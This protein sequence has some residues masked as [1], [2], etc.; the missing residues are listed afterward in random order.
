MYKH[1]YPRKRSHAP[2]L[3]PADRAI[4]CQFIQEPQFPYPET[5]WVKGWCNNLRIYL[6]S[7]DEPFCAEN[8]LE[9]VSHRALNLTA[10]A[11]ALEILCRS[12]AAARGET[13]PHFIDFEAAISAFYAT[14][15]CD[16]ND[17]K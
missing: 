6:I 1:Q 15:S 7:V 11:H 12:F 10:E 14:Y 9:Y 3:T 13:D 16:S 5:P 17:D 4:R 2:V 8:I